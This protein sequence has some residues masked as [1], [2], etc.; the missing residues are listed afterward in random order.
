M[1]ISRGT[2]RTMI[3]RRIG[4]TASTSFYATAFYNDVIDSRILSYSGQINKFA[5]NYYAEQTAYT[6]VD[7]AADAAYE[8]YNFPTNYRAF[9]RFERRM[10]STNRAPYEILRVVNF[11]DQDK[12][13]NSSR[14]L[15]ALPD[16]NANYEQ[17][18]SVWGNQFRLIP[19]PVN[20]SY[21]YRLIYLRK[22]VAASDDN[23]SLDIPDEWGE[24]IALAAGIFIMTQ[25]GDPLANNLAALLKQELAM[26]KD[27]FPRQTMGVDG[28]PALES[29]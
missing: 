1:A 2:M 17:V 18:V 29:M 9:V 7:D 20:N 4:D 3:Q 21:E 16:T 27:E 23:S 26:L 14:Q 8:F 19:A 11:E 24:V 5:P 6:G 28:I 22:P 25:Q 10:G 12:Y 15:I 13:I